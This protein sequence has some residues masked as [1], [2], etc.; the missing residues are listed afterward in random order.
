[1]NMQAIYP[2]YN[3]ELGDRFLLSDEGVKILGKLIFENK[4]NGLD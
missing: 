3:E 2:A 4:S 1:M